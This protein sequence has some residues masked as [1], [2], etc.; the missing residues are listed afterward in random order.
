M[1]ERDGLVAPVPPT[2]CAPGQLGHDVPEH[3]VVKLA[4]EVDKGQV[5]LRDEDGPRGLVLRMGAAVR[6]GVRQ[7]EGQPPSKQRCVEGCV[8]LRGRACCFRTDGSA[9]MGSACWPTVQN[10]IGVEGPQPMHGAAG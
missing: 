3:L 10:Q 7:G 6:L 8:G 9:D 1:D 4:R 2:E 5:V